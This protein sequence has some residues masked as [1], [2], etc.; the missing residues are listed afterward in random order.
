[1]PNFIFITMLA[2]FPALSTDMYLPA[3][4]TIQNQFGVTLAMVNLSLVLF[5]MVFSFCMLIY[6]PLSDRFGRK[7]VLIFGVGMYVLGSFLCAASVSITMLIGARVLQAAGA[8]AAFALALALVKDLYSGVRRQQLLAYIGVIIPLCPMLA[9]LFGSTMLKMFSW[10]WIFIAQGLLAAV[11]FYGTLV[12]KE[13]AIEKTKG[14]LLSVLSRYLVV[15][16]NVKFTTYCFA[17]SFMG[18][19]FFGFLAGSAD[20]YTRTFHT[21]EQLYAIY[22]GLN[23]FGFMVGSFACSRLCVS[24]SS[25]SILVASLAGI[26]VSGLLIYFL[27]A[28]PASFGACMLLMT[29][30]IGV[31]RPVSN[32]MMLDTVDR[33]IGTASAMITFTYYI[34]GSL[35]MQLVSFGWSSKI[36]VI[37]LMGIVGGIVPLIA[38]LFSSH[39]EKSEG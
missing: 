32:H 17:F 7:P 12:F 15:L 1:M 26:L 38:I 29:F 13:P 23:A 30:S 14:G 33:D 8:G 4:P 9:P 36:I 18:L 31:S 39:S 22:F 19:G 37:G 3:L 21:T 35:G 5:F 16:K 28:S 6:G 27:A 24:Y 20:I 10:R 25:K 11:A 34:F 2:A